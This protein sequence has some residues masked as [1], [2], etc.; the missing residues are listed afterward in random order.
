M[1]NNGINKQKKMSQSTIESKN[2]KEINN[3]KAPAKETILSPRF[4][5]TD[6]EAMKIWIYQ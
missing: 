5:T 3:G 6:F 2:K 1:V 4:Y